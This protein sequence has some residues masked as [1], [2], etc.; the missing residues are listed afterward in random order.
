[1]VYSRTLGKLDRGQPIF[2]ASAGTDLYSTPISLAI[3]KVDDYMNIDNFF[4]TA[5]LQ[6]KFT[7]KTSLNIS[8]M[9][10]LTQEDLQEHRTSNQFARDGEG[11]EIPTLMGMSTIRR[12]QRNYTDNI[13]TYL[14][15]ELN[16]GNIRHK[17]LLGY[18]YTQRISP[19][20]NSSQNARGYL[21]ADGQGFIS[22]YNP[23]NRDNYLFDGNGNPVPNVP[24]FNLAIP[25]YTFSEYESYDFTNAALVP[26]KYMVNGFYGQD[27]VEYGKL[28]ILLGLRQ[29]F[30]SDILAFK[31]TEEESVTQSAVIPRIGA[32][33]ALTKNINAY[34]NYSHGYQPQG[35]GFIGSPEVFGGPFDPLTSEMGEIGGKGEFF[36]QRL[37]ATVALYEITQNNIL[38]NANNPMNPDELM[39]R[40]QERARGTEFDLAGNITNNFSLTANYAFSRAIITESE[41]ES[42]IGEVKENAPV[43]QGGFWAKYQSSGGSINGLGLALGGN[44]VSARNTF[45]SILTLPAYFVSEAAVFYTMDKFRVSVNFR[46][47]INE[48][49]WIGGYDFNRLFP[50]EPRNF[51]ATVAYTFKS[52]EQKQDPV[53]NT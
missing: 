24:H 27:Q 25:D 40:G 49:F 36:N 20:G 44:F 39:Q 26:A 38:L 32:V 30:Y 37:F 53:E 31:T 48:V 12:F 45:S 15:N 28:R 17:I 21:R 8:Y 10:Y 3:A 42:Q 35:A 51:L 43:H 19:I 23:D 14:V 22:A 2:G 1:M 13:S 41:N 6:H 7:V 29:E 9:K 46:D 47:L 50:G 4:I 5:S 33:Y 11:N 34:D 18:D 16:T 52:D